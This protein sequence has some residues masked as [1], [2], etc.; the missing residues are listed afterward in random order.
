MSV[1]DEARRREEGAEKRRGRSDVPLLLA[2]DCDEEILIAARKQ[3]RGARVDDVIEFRQASVESLRPPAPPTPSRPY[4]FLVTNMP[5]GIRSFN[6]RGMRQIYSSFGDVYRRHFVGWN[7]GVLV[8]DRA[9]SHVIEPSLIASLRVKSGGLNCHVM[10]LVHED[11]SHLDQ[12]SHA[13]V[14]SSNK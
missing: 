3:A 14:L 5:W 4:G 13:D 7:L 2:A 12:S 1:V 8:E 9:L 11:S 6:H 10:R